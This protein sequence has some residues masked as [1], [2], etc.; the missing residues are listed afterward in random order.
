MMNQKGPTIRAIDGCLLLLSR[1]Q[2]LSAVNRPDEYHKV[3]IQLLLR[4]RIQ[5]VKTRH[6]FV[7]LLGIS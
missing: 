4:L 7:G 1:L 5:A 6:P 3:E 2:F